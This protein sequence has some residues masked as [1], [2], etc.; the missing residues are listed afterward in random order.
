[1]IPQHWQPN[2]TVLPVRVVV[3]P[4]AQ[5]L[6]LSGAAPGADPRLTGIQSKIPIRR[7]R[8]EGDNDAVTAQTLE[9][10]SRLAVE[11]SRDPAMIDHA[12]S[13]VAGVARKDYEGE[14]ARVFDHVKATV[15]YVHDPAGQ[16]TLVEPRWLLWVVGSEDCDGH[17]ALVA[18]LGLALGM[19]AAFCT[20]ATTTERDPRTG[21]VTSPWAH[22]YALLGV[23]KG[24]A[25]D[26]V[27]AD[28]AEGSYLGW[29]PP[30]EKVVRKRGWIVANP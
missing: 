19:G 27:A 14:A 12:R 24:N 6:G 5:L 3:A 23:P 7:W 25:V 8:L 29:E 2:N 26:W 22:V 11:A 13:V 4:P 16:E 28:T 21:L 18:A 10:M 30:A 15:R 1:M 9:I 20:V 17:A